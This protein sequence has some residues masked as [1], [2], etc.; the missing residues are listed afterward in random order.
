MNMPIHIRP[1]LTGF[2]WLRD[3]G[4][5]FELTIPSELAYGDSGSPPKIPGGSVLVFSIEIISIKGDE[6]DLVPAARCN[7]TTREKCSEKETQYLDKVST[8]TEVKIT[9]ELSRLNSL[10]GES[11]SMKPDLAA[12]IRKRAYMLQQL[13]GSVKEETDQDASKEL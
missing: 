4:D 2:A 6:A 12:W 5:K 7:V 11:R 1:Q 13:A 10:R 9:T 3:L 8:W